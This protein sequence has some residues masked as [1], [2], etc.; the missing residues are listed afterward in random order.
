[1]ASLNIKDQA[2]YAAKGKNQTKIKKNKPNQTPTL[3]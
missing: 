2:I 1:M 3:P